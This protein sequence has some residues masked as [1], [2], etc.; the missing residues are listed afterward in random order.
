MYFII[1]VMIVYADDKKEGQYLSSRSESRVIQAAFRLDR[2]PL[3]LFVNYSLHQYYQRYGSIAHCSCRGCY[4]CMLG[5]RMCKNSYHTYLVGMLYCRY[6]Q[7]CKC[8]NR[9]K[10]S[11]MMDKHSSLASLMIKLQ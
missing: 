5:L 11:L 3:S 7:Y 2:R 10:M 6:N 8:C 9:N 4:H 1:L